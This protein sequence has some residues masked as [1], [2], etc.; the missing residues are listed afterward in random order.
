MGE[1]DF[2]ETSKPMLCN[3]ENIDCSDLRFSNYSKEANRMN[4]EGF[5]R[6]KI[7]IE[8]MHLPSS[9][10]I[11]DAFDQHINYIEDLNQR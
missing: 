5:F 9:D 1:I 3:I 11:I 10:F 8:M 2:S 6:N 7:I 4:I